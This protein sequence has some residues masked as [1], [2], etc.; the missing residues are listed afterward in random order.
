MTGPQYQV[1]QECGVNVTLSD[2]HLPSCSQGTGTLPDKEEWVDTA[3]GKFETDFTA[4]I[5]E[6][7]MKVIESLVSSQIGEIDEVSRDV[8]DN[9]VKPALPSAIMVTV[10]VMVEQELLNGD[11]MNEL[12]DLYRFDPDELL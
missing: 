10:Q 8:L 12:V 11:K 1:C 4:L 6:R 3:I 9:I 7:A 5:V 2:L